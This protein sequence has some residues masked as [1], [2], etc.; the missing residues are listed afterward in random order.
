MSNHSSHGC[1]RGLKEFFVYKYI[2]QIVFANEDTMKLAM[3]D[4]D[5]PQKHRKFVNWGA[6]ITFFDNYLIKNDFKPQELYFTSMGWANRDYALLCDTF[7]YIDA[8]LKIFSGKNKIDNCPSNVEFVDLSGFGLNGMARLRE[9]YQNSIAILIPTIESNDVPNGATVLI[10]ALAV[11]KS[12][13]T[14]ESSSNYINVEK[15]GVG[16]VVPRGDKQGWI[17]AIDYILSHPTERIIMGRKA[18]ELAE[19][20]YNLSLFTEKIAKELENLSSK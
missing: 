9:Y 2:D 14:T 4:Y 10:E 13:I 18:R 11:G 5:V 15:E 6:N 3:Q 8:K 20:K 7:K 17:K 19:R 1:L 12:I 16:L